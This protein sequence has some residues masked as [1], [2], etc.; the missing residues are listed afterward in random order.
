M[1][2]KRT[3]KLEVINKEF[4]MWEQVPF[5]LQTVEFFATVRHL[6]NAGINPRDHKGRVWEIVTQEMIQEVFGKEGKMKTTSPHLDPNNRRAMLRIYWQIFG[7][8]NVTNNEFGTWLVKGYIAQEMDEVVDWAAAAAATAKEL[9]MWVGSQKS[10]ATD[11]KPGASELNGCCPSTNGGVGCSQLRSTEFG[12]VSMVHL[13]PASAA[14]VLLVKEYHDFLL[15]LQK[16]AQKKIERLGEEKK[17][18]DEKI[19]GLRFNMWDRKS[20]AIEATEAI[21][22]AE[23]DLRSLVEGLGIL[24]EEVRWLSV[25]LT[26]IVCNRIYFFPPGYASNTSLALLFARLN[27]KNTK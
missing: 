25:F 3:K 5:R 9:D 17:G 6:N 19:I 10:S 8:A 16:C 4:P 12:I 21:T 24:E 11:F 20:A 7:S 14:D 1:A 23:A 13:H 18:Q 22:T 27:A 2:S 26:C 15:E